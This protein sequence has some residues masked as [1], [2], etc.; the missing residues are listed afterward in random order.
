MKILYVEDELAQN[1]PRIT[2]LFGKYLGQQRVKQLE[3]LERD[4]SGFGATPEEIKRIVE[5]S[6]LLQVEYRFPEALLEII[7]N[8][9]QYT[10]FII[11]RNLLENTYTLKE[12]QAIEPGYDKTYDDRYAGREGDYLLLKLIFKLTLSGHAN[13]LEHVY[14]LTVYSPEYELRSREEIERLI[15]LRRFK[16]QNFIEKG[17]SKDLDRL[18]N[19]VNN[20]LKI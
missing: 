1:I 4:T 18:Q 5:E 11:D 13:F 16:A 20:L 17:S 6:H 15:D 14:F 19:E 12:V 3:K 9:Y 2:R 10:M 7:S 8:Y